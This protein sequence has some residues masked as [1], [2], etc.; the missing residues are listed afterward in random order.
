MPKLN[1]VIASILDSL[2]SAQHKSNLTTSQLAEQYRTDNTL[3]YLQLPNAVMS[4]VDITL[5][6][7]INSYSNPVM[8]KK[9]LTESNDA[10]L[11][12][13]AKFT[14]KVL[15]RTANRTVAENLYAKLEPNLSRNAKE[16]LADST[17]KEILISRIQDTL[18]TSGKNQKSADDTTTAV[19]KTINESLSENNEV[20]TAEKKALTDLIANARQRVFTVSASEDIGD[21]DVI[22]DANALADMPEEAIQTLHITTKM[23][24]YRWIEGDTGEFVPVD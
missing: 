7:A 20:A 10:T 2:D 3:K 19:L 8:L 4:E 11:A 22:I 5:R 1:S 9:S 6:Y 16:I 24:N 18:Y 15:N 12:K 14:P 13:E 21:L 23:Q 17:K